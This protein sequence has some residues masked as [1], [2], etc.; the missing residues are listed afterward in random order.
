M[1]FYSDIKRQNQHSNIERHWLVFQNFN[2]KNK[3]AKIIDSKTVL[4][5]VCSVTTT[6][7]L[8]WLGMKKS[9]SLHSTAFH[10]SWKYFSPVLPENWED[11]VLFDSLRP[12]FNGILTGFPCWWR[13]TLTNSILWKWKK[14]IC[15]YTKHE[16]ERKRERVLYHTTNAPS[17]F[18]CAQVKSLWPIVQWSR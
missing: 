8:I 1:S 18:G 4:L 15:N 17:P 2:L 7:S 6:K 13:E 16:R 9:S 14:K 3:I 10:P 12:A 11:S 5:P